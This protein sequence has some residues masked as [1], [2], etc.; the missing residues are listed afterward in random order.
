MR[1]T[2][3]DYFWVTRQLMKIANTTAGGRVVSVLEGGYRIQ[4]GPVSAFVR[5]VASHVRALAGG[6]ADTWESE[7]EREALRRE[8]A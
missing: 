2:E 6:F 1:L 3:E 4:G 5:S 7:R 8:V